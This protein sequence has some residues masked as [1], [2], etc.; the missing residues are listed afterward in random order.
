MG[1]LCEVAVLLGR[2]GPSLQGVLL[3]ASAQTGQMLQTGTKHST[4]V[5]MTSL[6]SKEHGLGCEYTHKNKEN[7]IMLNLKMLNNTNF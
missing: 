5:P 7:S 6:C 2:R 3:V 1:P 4:T